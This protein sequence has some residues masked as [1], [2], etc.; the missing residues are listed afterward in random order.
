MLLVSFGWVGEKVCLFQLSVRLHVS[1]ETGMLSGCGRCHVVL[2]FSVKSFVIIYVYMKNLK[3]HF[4]NCV[5]LCKEIFDGAESIQ[6]R[7]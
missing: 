5:L 1:V 2:V 4:K 3:H 6:S 7:H